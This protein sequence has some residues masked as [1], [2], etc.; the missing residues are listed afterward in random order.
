MSESGIEYLKLTTGQFGIWQ[1]QQLDLDNPV[2]NVGEY[3]EIRGDL[4]VD[5]FET[6]L[7]HVVREVDAFH[8]RFSGQDAM[9]R[10]YVAVS[11]EWPLH[12]LDVSG[13][14]DPRAAAGEWM[15]ADARRP[16]YLREGPV[17]RQALVKVD[18]DLFFWYQ[19][20]HHIAFDALSSSNVCARVAHV[21]TSLL[22]GRTPALR[23]FGRFSVLPAADSAYRESADYDSDREFWRNSLADFPDARSASGQ[24]ILRGSRVP[25]RHM[26]VIDPDGVAAL[27]EAASRLGTSL[28]GLVI[29]ASAVFLH[30]LTG[31]EDLILGL[32]VTG[33]MGEEVRD[34]P[35]M[36][37]NTLPI[38]M[39]IGQGESVRDLMRRVTVSSSNALRRRRYPYGDILRDLKLVDGSA[40]FGLLVNV[41][42]ADS[43]LCFGECPV[44]VHNISNGPVDDLEI[45]VYDR[46]AEAGMKI[47]FDGNPDLHDE[48]SCAVL[49]R[50]FRRVLTWLAAAAPGDALGRAEVLQAAERRQVLEEWNDTRRDLPPSTLPALFE[51]QAGRTPDAIALACGDDCLSYRELNERADRLA[52]ALKVRG[53]GPESVVAVVMARSAQLFTALLAVVKAGAAYMPV[54]PGYPVERVAFMLRDARPAIILASAATAAEIPGHGA[55]LVVD[56][57]AMAAELAAAAGGAAGTGGAATGDGL[58]ARVLAAHPAYVIYTSGST[59]TPKGVTVS[60]SGVAS[61]LATQVEQFAVGSGGRVLQFA[62]PGFDASM[63]EVVMALGSGASLV[64]APDH[65][66]LAGLRAG[67]CGGPVRG[68]APYGAAGR[69][70]RPG[71][72]GPVAGADLGDRRGRARP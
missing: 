3:L 52:L 66:P 1:D 5:L 38:R 40:L 10:Q 44:V 43:A 42:A 7:R 56:D 51:S 46:S 4:D 32:P 25:V 59:G 69:A 61:L 2:Y 35:G 68:V 23:T 13:A 30:K 34:I 15:R 70:R 65:E 63:W 28:S 27:R 37:T 12:V 8:L 64:V 26:E 20:A 41:M 47:S 58:A 21:Y 36:M 31:T 9:L 33:R 50:R 45:S 60:H 71:A 53:V 17:F 57:R 29:A 62:S 72:G 55:V 14:A 11:D 48:A 22:T 49:G 54:D 19:I 24:R 6:A 67:G 16:I 39:T 18:R